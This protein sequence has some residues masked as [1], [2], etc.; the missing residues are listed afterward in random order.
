MFVNATIRDAID[1]EHASAV[2]PPNE[3]RI[4]IQKIISAFS[5]LRLPLRI[6]LI[7]FGGTPASQELLTSLGFSRSLLLAFDATN[8]SILILTYVC[9]SICHPNLLST[10]PVRLVHPS[11]RHLKAPAPKSDREMGVTDSRHRGAP[12]AKLRKGEWTCN[13]ASKSLICRLPTFSDL[14]SIW[15]KVHN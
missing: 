5:R 11:D 7:S 3:I 4:D 14:S 10:L 6:P 2:L 12:R 8:W 1:R 15:I 13:A 9:I